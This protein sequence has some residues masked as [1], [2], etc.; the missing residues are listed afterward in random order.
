MELAAGEGLLAVE[1][2]GLGSVLTSRAARAPLVLL[3]PRN[4]GRAAWVFV[5]TLGGGLVDGDE[6][7]LRARVEPGAALYLATQAS[8]KIYA[9]RADGSGAAQR[10][11]LDVADGGLAVSVPEPVV[12]FAGA[13]YRQDTHAYLAGG[14]SAILV[15]ALTSGR[16]ARGER[17]D[18]ASLD[19]L[20][21]VERDGVELVRDRLLLHPTHGEL[22]ARL[23]RVDALATIVAVGPATAGLRAHLAGSGPA[24]LERRAALVVAPSRPRPDVVVAR[25]A[26]TS[27]EQLLH[28]LRALLA[29]LP[30]L[31]GDDPFA[32]RA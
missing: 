11:V 8:T 26:A 4:H 17:W 3:E 9:A 22:R 23:G 15:D 10:L 12:C 31:L 2:R 14:G 13:R 16:S 21:T 20:T 30:A 28:G 25:L 18:L 19:L 24:R 7:T 6:V 5:G 1:P 32:P 29:P 27:V